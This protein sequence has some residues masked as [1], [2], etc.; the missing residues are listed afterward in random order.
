M[1]TEAAKSE[2]D[3]VVHGVVHGNSAFEELL[4]AAEAYL[5]PSGSSIR[6][7]KLK[8]LRAAIDRARAG[9]GE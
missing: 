2:G 3:G 9:A 7:P 1:T 5:E 8:R 6:A 4:A